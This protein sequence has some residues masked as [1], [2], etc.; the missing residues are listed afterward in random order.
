[1]ARSH[2]SQPPEKPPAMLPSLPDDTKLPP[3]NSFSLIGT[4]E[5]HTGICLKKDYD[6]PRDVSR[7]GPTDPGS[8]AS[9]TMEALSCSRLS[10]N[11]IMI[12][13]I[14]TRGVTANGLG[15]AMFRDSR[16]LTTK[17]VELV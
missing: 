9:T 17:Q 5:S 6:L 3:C 2:F 15:G 11:K 10:L 14:P 13:I 12:R 1:M 16:V 4:R 8:R 7:Y